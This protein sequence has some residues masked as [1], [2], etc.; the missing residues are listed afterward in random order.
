M[1]CAFYT[2]VCHPSHLVTAF[3]YNCLLITLF[4]NMG[5]NAEG[6]LFFVIINYVTSRCSNLRIALPT[7]ITVILMK[8][9]G[10]FCTIYFFNRITFTNR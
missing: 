1:K 8:R 2:S 9:L 5:K 4:P 6:K 7:G 3:I 10:I